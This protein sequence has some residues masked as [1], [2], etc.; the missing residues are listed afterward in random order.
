MY[1][2]R[3]ISTYYNVCI[4]IIYI[5]ERSFFDVLVLTL[6]SVLFNIAGSVITS[7]GNLCITPRIKYDPVSRMKEAKKLKKILCEGC[8]EFLFISVHGSLFPVLSKFSS[9]VLI[10]CNLKNMQMR[11]IIICYPCQ[12]TFIL[13]FLLLMFTELL[14]QYKVKLWW[15]L[16]FPLPWRPFHRWASAQLCAMIWSLFWMRCLVSCHGEMT[17]PW[18]IIKLEPWITLE[19]A[20][21]PRLS[22]IFYCRARRLDKWA[23]NFAFQK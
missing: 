1:S 5:P 22:I 7:T 9:V 13:T 3:P 8:G 6:I 15:S 4:Y 18:M 11:E 23:W 10:W 12:W 21:F 14:W 17:R 2:C 20:D 19:R 16:G